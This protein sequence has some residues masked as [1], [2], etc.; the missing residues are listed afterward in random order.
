M[1]PLSWFPTA[2][3]AADIYQVG[4]AMR[5]LCVNCGS[6]SLRYSEYDFTQGAE[7]ASLSDSIPIV[8]KLA[9]GGGSPG[10]GL[11]R[12][13]QAALDLAVMRMCGALETAHAGPPD[14]IAHRF[15]RGALAHNPPTWLDDR[16]LA[17][18][19]AA[20]P[21]A[22]LHLPPALRAVEICRDRYPD[23]P[24]LACFDTAFHAGLPQVSRRLP[25]P[26]R[27]AAEVERCGFHGLS[28][29]YVTAA[30]GDTGR[31]VIAHLGNGASLTAVQ[32]G[33]SLDTTMG[34]TPMSGLMMG[35]RCG[36]LDPGVCVYLARQHGMT[37]D[38]LEQLFDEQCGLLGVSGTTADMRALLEA[39]G[40]NSA[41]RDAIFLYC[42][43]A[44]KHL[45]AMATVL[46]GLDTLVF[47]GGIGANAPVI[48]AMIC[49]NLAHLGVEL[50]EARNRDSQAIISAAA[51]GCGVRVVHTD[52]QIVM[53]RHAYRLR[54]GM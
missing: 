54:R 19:Q 2:A 37:P 28:C 41:A 22:P 29:E 23:T 12:R 46:G 38:A 35:T 47:T 43:I 11:L 17:Q 5:I 20:A 4:K 16:S 9:R 7:R 21:L 51:A 18:L 30:L 13:E 50:D 6:S 53:A 8:Q 42:H 48:R 24:Q 52:E 14:V 32:N 27:Y 33:R 39:R 31:T 25:L 34:F 10:G 26:S 15:V 1:C 44:R 40:R 36:D 45:G 49:Q 3:R